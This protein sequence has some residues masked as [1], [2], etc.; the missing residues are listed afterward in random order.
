MILVQLIPVIF[1]ANVSFQEPAVLVDLKVWCLTL[2][3]ALTE[4]YFD[5]LGQQLCPP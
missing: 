5:T 1:K 2:S 4:S 3:I